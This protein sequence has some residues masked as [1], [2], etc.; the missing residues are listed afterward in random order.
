MLA[1]GR[2]DDEEPETTNKNRFSGFLFG[3]TALF[4]IM[5]SYTLLGAII[6][7]FLEGNNDLQQPIYIQKSREDCLKELWLI[8]GE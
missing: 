7:K 4:L 8:T 2:M 5:T 1:F 6:F 3:K